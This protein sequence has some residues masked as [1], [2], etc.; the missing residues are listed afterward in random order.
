[1]K[2]ENVQIEKEEVVRISQSTKSSKKKS[3][4]KDTETLT[5]QE[6]VI[7]RWGS[8]IKQIPVSE[9]NKLIEQ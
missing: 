8:Y 5:E 9:Y 1:M 4:L 3:V 7:L 2:F 6:Y